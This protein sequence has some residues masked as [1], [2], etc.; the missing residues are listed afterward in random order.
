MRVIDAGTARLSTTCRR[1]AQRRFVGFRSTSGEA[2]TGPC[3][4]DPDSG[5]LL[6]NPVDEDIRNDVEPDDER[7]GGS[8]EATSS[9]GTRKLLGFGHFRASGR[10][11][12]TRPFAV[13]VHEPRVTVVQMRARC[14]SIRADLATLASEA[15]PE[16][17]SVV[18]ARSRS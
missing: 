1:L 9:L 4:R 10:E 18:S 3:R 16:S 13:R 12:L 11:V 7:C 14:G 15:T 2:T 6:A 8:G 17:A 5:G